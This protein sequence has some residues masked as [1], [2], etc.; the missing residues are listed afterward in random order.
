[1]DS[2][3][4]PMR[5]LTGDIDVG[6][7]DEIVLVLGVGSID[8]E[9]VNEALEEDGGCAAAAE[10]S[11]RVADVHAVVV[12]AEGSIRDCQRSFMWPCDVPRATDLS[13][14][15]L[16]E[17]HAPDSVALRGTSYI[18]LGP[19]RV[20]VGEDLSREQKALLVSDMR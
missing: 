12:Q 19:Q 16:I 10:T 17:G 9:S 3:P 1:M 4:E 5:Q 7:S 6:P 20:A 8:N 11:S 14:V 18:E 15:T 2:N 13:H